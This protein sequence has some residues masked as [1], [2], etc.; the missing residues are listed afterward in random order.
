MYLIAFVNCMCIS[1]WMN[2]KLWEWNGNILIE[3][4]KVSNKLYI[5]I[6]NFLCWFKSWFFIVDLNRDKFSLHP[7]KTIKN[8]KNWETVTYRWFVKVKK[9][10]QYLIVTGRYKT[11]KSSICSRLVKHL[12]AVICIGFESFVSDV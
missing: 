3:L 10:Y 9:F 12:R 11:L 2:N 5:L 7:W 4:T 1:L 6:E 8:Y